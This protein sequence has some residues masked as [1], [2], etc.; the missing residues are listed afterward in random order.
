MKTASPRTG[1]AGDEVAQTNSITPRS[2]TSYKL[3]KRAESNRAGP[4]YATAD[5]ERDAHRL[6]CRTG[7]HP[8]PE[9]AGWPYVA[10]RNVTTAATP[11]EPGAV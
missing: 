7:T 2:L 3:A 1:T 8:M 9:G 6:G 11:P 10:R 4:W 5:A